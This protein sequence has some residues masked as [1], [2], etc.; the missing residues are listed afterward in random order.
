MRQRCGRQFVSRGMSEF[1]SWAERPIDYPLAPFSAAFLQAIPD[2]LEPMSGAIAAQLILYA[3][4][5]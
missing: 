3:R 2:R 5:R 1:E 4:A